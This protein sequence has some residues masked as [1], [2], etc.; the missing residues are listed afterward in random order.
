MPSVASP[1][2]KGKSHGHPR[3]HAFILDITRPHAP[4]GGCA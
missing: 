1:H 3:L 2:P 4:R